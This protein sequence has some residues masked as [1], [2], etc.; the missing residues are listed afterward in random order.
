M[1]SLIAFAKKE[2][3]EQ[4]R[5][6]RMMV[7]G[8]VFV[9]FG[10]LSP[11]L[12]KLTPWMMS[13]FADSMTSG[14]TVNEITVTDLDSWMQFYKNAPIVLIAF[15]LIQSS[16]FTKEYQSGTLVLSLTKGLKR[17]KV[18]L[19]KAFTLVTLWTVGYWLCFG[20]AYLYTGFYW[21]NALAQNLVFSAV[22]WY[23]FGLWVIGMMTLFSTMSRSNT[24]V[25]L[26]IVA[27]IIACYLVGTLPRVGQ[28]MPTQ[29]MDG[30][31]LIYGTARAEDYVKALLVTGGTGIVCFIAS[32]PVF[33]KKYL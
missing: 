22:C 32:I 26:G 13:L 4:L 24:G 7:L 19:S 18:V 12:A 9:L 28:Y 23:V 29:L 33:N 30:N 1:K 14:I 21:D 5:T 8:I 31:S 6:S 11:A 27:V 25:L 2:I 15:V 16:I 20:V 3:T 10:I 17:H